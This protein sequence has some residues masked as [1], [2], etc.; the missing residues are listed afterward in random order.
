MVVL[1][2]AIKAPPNWSLHLTSFEWFDVK[3][4]PFVCAMAVGIERSVAGVYA[5]MG[6]D[7]GRIVVPSVAA[8]CVL[9]TCRCTRSGQG[10]PTKHCVRQISMAVDPLVQ[11]QKPL[12]LVF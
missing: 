4:S 5:G 2:R 1:P 12:P 6:R 7:L 3:V 9:V 11:S 8:F 10:P